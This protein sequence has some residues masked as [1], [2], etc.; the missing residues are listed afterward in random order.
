MGQSAVECAFREPHQSLGESDAELNWIQGG[1]IDAVGVTAPHYRKGEQ[2]PE[3]A[4]LTVIF[5]STVALFSDKSQMG[6]LDSDYVAGPGL[7]R[8]QG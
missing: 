1:E 6:A 5:E 2:A 7:S 8:G 4:D 3:F